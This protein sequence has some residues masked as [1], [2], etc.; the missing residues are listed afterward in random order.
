MQYA[1][2]KGNDGR[3]HWSIFEYAPDNLDCVECTKGSHHTLA[4]SP[5]RGYATP[6]AA[7]EVIQRIASQKAFTDVSLDYAH[8]PVDIEGVD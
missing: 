2:K 8:N 4:V 6:Q 3:W 5:P 1:I 7:R